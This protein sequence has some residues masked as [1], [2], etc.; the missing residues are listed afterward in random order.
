MKEGR[1]AR[2]AGGYLPAAGRVL[3]QSP[4]VSL[5]SATFPSS[6]CI[7]SR[8]WRG[9]APALTYIPGC[10][11][12]LWNATNQTLPETTATALLPPL[13]ATCSPVGTRRGNDGGNL[14]PSSLHHLPMNLS[15]Q[16]LHTSSLGQVSEQSSHLMTPAVPSARGRTAAGTPSA[17]VKSRLFGDP[18][19]KYQIGKF[20]PTLSHCQQPGARENALGRL[21]STLQPGTAAPWPIVPTTCSRSAGPGRPEEDGDGIKSNPGHPHGHA[22]SPRA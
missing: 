22:L 18:V 21:P 12:D 14:S 6:C 10:S 19:F 3:Q 17:S 20:P 16:I 11:N 1:G 5:L 15:T 13:P 8:G 2:A 4:Q 9:D 7:G